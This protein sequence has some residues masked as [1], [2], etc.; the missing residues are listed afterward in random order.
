MPCGAEGESPPSS[1]FSPIG[2]RRKTNKT[3]TAL[4][5]RCVQP[6]WTLQRRAAV[7]KAVAATCCYVTLYVAL[8]WISFIQPLQ[9]A[10]YTP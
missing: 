2:P 10:S 9:G 6:L 4:V 7:V 1:R 8:D 5:F 3:M